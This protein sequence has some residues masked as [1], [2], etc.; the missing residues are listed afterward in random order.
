MSLLFWYQGCCCFVWLQ[1]KFGVLTVVIMSLMMFSKSFVDRLAIG[2]P[3]SVLWF[4]DFLGQRR[5]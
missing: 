2:L 1:L 3:F 4:V 5:H